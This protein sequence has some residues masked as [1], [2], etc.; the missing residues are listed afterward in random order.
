MFDPFIT[1]RLNHLTWLSLLIAFKND[2][3]HQPPPS[4]CPMTSP[5]ELSSLFA[6][7]ACLLFSLFIKNKTTKILSVFV[8]RRVIYRYSF[9]S[10]NLIVLMPISLILI[11]FLRIILRI[12]Y[13]YGTKFKK[14]NKSWL[15]GSVV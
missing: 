5:L 14:H 15:G 13:A 12:I 6:S 1:Q 11:I 9:P 2:F 7:K 4:G 3:I 10:T 8:Q